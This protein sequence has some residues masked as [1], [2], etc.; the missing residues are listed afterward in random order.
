MDL[1]PLLMNSS[2]LA[3]TSTFGGDP[4]AQ[5]V[6]QLNFGAG[7]EPLSLVRDAENPMGCTSYEKGTIPPLSVILV[8]RGE[9]SFVQKLDEASLAGAAGVVVINYEDK[10]LN[11]SAD[12]DDTVVLDGTLDDVAL[13]VLEQKDG[14]AV[15]NMLN[16]IEGDETLEVT[17]RVEGPP[18]TEDDDEFETPSKKDTTILVVN[19]HAVMNTVL[20]I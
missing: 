17:V 7:G 6:R 14:E 16:A 15:R 10:P 2:V 19:G 3:Y 12:A 4:A 13:M 5:G 11:P 1:M 9:C 20:D 8:D 18:A